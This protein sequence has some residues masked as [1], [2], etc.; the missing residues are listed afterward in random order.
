LLARA[1]S[2]LRRGGGARPHRRTPAAA[3]APPRR[4]S[5]NL[6]LY[7]HGEQLYVS[8]FETVAAHLASERARLAAAP[9]ELLLPALRALYERHVLNM[10]KIKDVLMFVQLSLLL[11]SSS[12]CS[13]NREKAAAALQDKMQRQKQRRG[14]TKTL[15]D[16]GSVCVR[17]FRQTTSTRTRGRSEF[18]FGKGAAAHE[19][20]NTRAH[21]LSRETAMSAGGS[22]R[23]RGAGRPPW[24]AAV[25]AAEDAAPGWQLALAGGVALAAGAAAAFILWRRWRERRIVA[26]SGPLAALQQAEASGALAE[27]WLPVERA[28]DAASIFRVSTRNGFLPIV[29]PLRALPRDFAELDEVVS[30]L[31]HF[32]RDA[33]ET[34]L[35]RAL[36]LVPQYRIVPSLLTPLEKQS[37]FRDYSI[38]VSALL[39]EGKI[40]SGKARARVPSNIA[41]PFVALAHELSERA[42]MSYDSYC[43]LAAAPPAPPH[44]PRPLR[45]CA[46]HARRRPRRRRRPDQRAQPGRRRRRPGAVVVGAAAQRLDVWLARGLRAGGGRRVVPLAAAAPDPR[47]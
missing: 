8:V 40:K 27:L 44:L 25:A 26:Q 46:R 20:E 12:F 19:C 15:L 47:L 11:L 4:Y 18:G 33:S 6:V 2:A 41:I 21:F 45:F 28:A 32:L 39:L 7:K 31:P 30:A 17:K 24:A 10:D 38:L 3:L 13:T 36:A 43:A 35:A 14:G 1:R 29:R 22:V 34:A 42:I 37:V 16:G 9:D 23:N 5:Y